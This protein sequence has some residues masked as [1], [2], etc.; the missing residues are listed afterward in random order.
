MAMTLDAVRMLDP[1]LYEST[2]WHLWFDAAEERMCEDFQ[3]HCSSQVSDGDDVKAV[4]IFEFDM[5]SAVGKD[6]PYQ[7]KEGGHEF[8]IVCERKGMCVWDV[9]V[10]GREAHAGNDHA[11]GRSAIHAAAKLIQHV[12]GLTD[13][14]RD[15]TFNVGTIA[16][17]SAPNVVPGHASL[18][19]EM[20]APTMGAFR[21]G[22]ERLERF[23]AEY[24]HPGL[25]Q[26]P[27]PITTKKVRPLVIATC[28]R[29]AC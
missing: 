20:R 27:S 5:D 26:S 2:S 12:E 16:G 6:V 4:M 22:V 1:H 8:H 23:A 17:G 9:E 25:E 15:L 28:L 10:S 19:I 7:N 29:R 24:R 13:Y 18:G 11:R 3:R 21:S 14:D